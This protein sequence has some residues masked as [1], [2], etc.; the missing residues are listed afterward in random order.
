MN[1]GFDPYKQERYFIR[2]YLKC[3]RTINTKKKY[4]EEVKIIKN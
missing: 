2:N 3:K 4:K 1:F